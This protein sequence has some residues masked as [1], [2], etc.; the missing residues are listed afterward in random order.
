[1]YTYTSVGSE[2]EY[3][4]VDVSSKIRMI[5]NGFILP[6]ISTHEGGVMDCDANF[7]DASRHI[8]TWLKIGG[9]V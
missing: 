2:K 6:W 3:K 9:G 8:G 1:M 7:I 5:K 4:F